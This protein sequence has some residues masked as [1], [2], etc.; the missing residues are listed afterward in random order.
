[1]DAQLK[2]HLGPKKKF[3]YPR[4]KVEKFLPIQ[5]V[6]FSKKQADKNTIWGIAGQIKRRLS[7]FAGLP[8]G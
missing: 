3:P 5:R 6:F 2:S 4:A 7:S 8:Q 1:M